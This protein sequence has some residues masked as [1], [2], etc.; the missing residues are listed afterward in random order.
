[1][2]TH[3]RARTH[4]HTRTDT[5]ARARTRA[6]RQVVSEHT[7]KHAHPGTISQVPGIPFIFSIVMGV[8]AHC[9]GKAVQCAGNGRESAVLSLPSFAAGRLSV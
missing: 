3:T 5:H 8:G 6:D 9:T 1:L 2:K 4:T 7:H